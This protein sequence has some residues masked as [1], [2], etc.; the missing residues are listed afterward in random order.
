MHHAAC[1]MSSTKLQVPPLSIRPPRF[2][3][4]TVVASISNWCIS[5]LNGW[6]V[7]R[8]RVIRL[9]QFPEPNYQLVSGSL[10]EVSHCQAEWSVCTV[11]L[12]PPTVSTT[13]LNGAERCGKPPISLFWATPGQAPLLNWYCCPLCWGSVAGKGCTGQVLE[14]QRGLLLPMVPTP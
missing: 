10:K 5:T 2:C 8:G 4:Y 7:D 6:S 1:S 13:V 9:L 14:P 11:Q 12:R 3:L